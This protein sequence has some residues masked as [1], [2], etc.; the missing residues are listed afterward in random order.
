MSI[1]SPLTVGQK[2]PAFTLPDQT[3]QKTALRDFAGKW[4]VLYFYPKDDTPGCTIEAIDFTALST[5]FDKLGTVVLGV[6]PDSPQ[7]HC[8]FIDKHH[9]GIRRLSDPDHEVLEKYNAWRLKKNYGKEYM[10]VARSTV[11]IDPEGKIAHLWPNVKA[12]GHA[13]AVRQKLAT[14][15]H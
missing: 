4:V 6:S 2:A 9:L 7:K 8:S 14:L 3:G 11:L 5:A 12:E 10:G 1:E 15:Q 13:E